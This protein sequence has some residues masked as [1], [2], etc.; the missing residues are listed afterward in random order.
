MNGAHDMGG[1]HGLGPIDAE[2]DE[3]V[4]HHDWE[5]RVLALTLASG[6]MGKWNI[7]ISRH[8][9]ENQPPAEYLANSYYQTWLVG[10]EKL[11]VESGLVT[12]DEI[13]NGRSAAPLPD[14]LEERV[15]KAEAVEAVLSRGD[16]FTVEDDI[17]AKFAV[18]EPVRVLNNHPT[19]HTRAPRYVRGKCG[20]V[21]RDHGVF[22]FADENS[23][24]PGHRVGQHVYSVCFPAQ[25]L[26]GPDAAA[27]DRINVDLWDGHLE[28][29][30]S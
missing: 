19:H 7:D 25:E 27:A 24:G 28:A 14:D 5:R 29:A 15:L 23:K 22:V 8:A 4:F 12:A 10:L 6:A 2:I 18:G 9:R 16:N 3:P 21:E 11:L 20:V 13:A 17:P 1:M 30:P 26:W